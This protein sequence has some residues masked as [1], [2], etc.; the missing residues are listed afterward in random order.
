MRDELISEYNG[1]TNFETWKVN[2]ELIDGIDPNDY[3][4]MDEAEIRDSLKALVEEVLEVHPDL[5]LSYALSFVNS[6]DFWQIAE[7]I[8]EQI[9]EEEAE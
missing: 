7:N 2:L 3:R 9:E 4:G 6:V 5:A 1:W 8:K